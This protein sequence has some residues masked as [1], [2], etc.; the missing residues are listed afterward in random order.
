M[1]IE[2]RLYNSNMDCVI[3]TFTSN[4]NWQLSKSRAIFIDYIWKN[5][6]GYLPQTSHF[7]DKKT[8]I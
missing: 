2:Y 4:E 8:H 1:K 5:I 3:F 7:T 6:T